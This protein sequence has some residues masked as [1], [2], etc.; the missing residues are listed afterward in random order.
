MIIVFSNIKG[1]VGKSTLVECFAN[2]LAMKGEKVAV[3]DADVQQS[4]YRQRSQ[5]IEDYPDEVIPWPVMSMNTYQNE[6]QI[7]HLMRELSKV[8]GYILVDCPGNV[9]DSA[10][11]HIFKSADAAVIPLSFDRL[12]LD[13]TKMFYSVF[14]DVSEAKLFFVP[15]RINVTEGT[16]EYRKRRNDAENLLKSVGILTP[17][18][19]QS[20]IFNRLSTVFPLDTYQENAVRYAFETILNNFNTIIP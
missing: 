1:G 20:V 10:L 7:P 8:D 13:A 16:H 9:N 6:K 11:A 19:K 5:D 18:I 3:V 15:N 4:L 12:T 17:R 2:Y 14:R